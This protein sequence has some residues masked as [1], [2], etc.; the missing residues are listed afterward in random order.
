M[1]TKLLSLLL[2]GSA[3]ATHAQIPTE[4]TDRF[5]T[6]MDSLTA[7]VLTDT[8][9]TLGVS[10]AITIPGYGSWKGAS[11]QADSG[12]PLTT[13][14]TM[15]IGSHSK[16]YLAVILLRLQE[17]GV[18]SLD[19]QIG[20][21]FDAPITNVDMTVTI[22]QLL[23]HQSGIFD[24]SN[25]SYDVFWGNIFTD[26][27]AFWQY[28]DLYT[29]IDEP[30]FPKG[31]AYRYS[32]VGYSIAANIVENVTG[33]SYSHN[34]H[35]YITTPLGLTMTYDGAE[36]TA[37][38]DTVE[39]SASYV[40]DQWWP[41]L[42]A[43]ATASLFRG[44]G[45]IVAT[46][47]DVVDFYQALFHTDFLTQD[48]M[49]QLLDFESG[50]EYGLG[51]QQIYLGSIKRDVYYHGGYIVGFLSDV[52]HDPIT[53]ATYFYC[54]NSNQATADY[55][56]PLHF[57]FSDYFPKKA[58]D[59]GI[60][61]VLSP[62]TFICGSTPAPNVKMK[63]FGSNTV[64]SATIN[65]QVDNGPAQSFPWTGNIASGESAEFTLPAITASVGSHSIA[66]WT[67]LP[68]GGVE[69]NLY[70][71]IARAEFAVNPQDNIPTSF[72]ENF[73]N[74][75]SN[76]QIWNSQNT[77]AHQWRTTY[78]TANS[79][80]HSLAKEGMNNE[81]TGGVDYIDLPMLHLTATPQQL[82]F[83]YAYQ[84]YEGSEDSLQ[85]LISSDCGA[86]WTSL[87]AKQGE[88]LALGITTVPNGYAP[89]YPLTD[90][91]WHTEEISLDTFAE[92]NVLIRFKYIN[93]NGGNIFIDD[94]HVGSALGIA[95]FN[96]NIINV[97]PNPATDKVTITGLTDGTVVSLYAISGQKLLEVT[98]NG[99]TA[100][101]I[102]S[103]AKGMYFLNTSKGSSKIVKR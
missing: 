67:S 74:E 87:Y 28:D 63:N 10:F 41:R 88:E 93:D 50:S 69:G 84:A 29:M 81:N 6:V 78:L 80:S 53:G 44:A 99:D 21:Y 4:M 47:Q 49:N 73:E 9:E 43:V 2:I 13:N 94:I 57:A 54:I 27:E 56:V 79:G 89:Y 39:E 1:K 55:G 5:Q 82:S 51:I 20:E 14:M 37:A 23:Q 30:H 66:V 15:G 85:V 17:E 60:L 90:E 22:R 103:L 86:T 19:D 70:N 38:L 96:K 8:G 91:E 58:N 97:Y 26:L 65:Y 12:M 61:N 36:D 52:V 33:N 71:D 77:Q 59:T 3:I 25:D 72:L 92:S 83:N 68:N 11:G 35:Q 48:S 64:T 24:P 62:T 34:L 75:S 7:N 45:T 31:T 98:V 102:S 100:I 18:L 46:P 95:D 76:L 16:L 40:L 42:G 101:D 32:N